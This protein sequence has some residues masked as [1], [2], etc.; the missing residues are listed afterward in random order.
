[1]RAVFAAITLIA[2]A[3][4]GGGP[5][6]YPP[7]A[8]ARFHADCPADNPVCVCT[9]EKFTEAM[10]YEEYEAALARM[11]ERGLMD[12]R[13]TRASAAC[14]ERHRSSSGQ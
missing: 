4:C 3:G 10:P 11:E 5:H 2:L 7:E 8:Q 1:M 13:M 6:P 14:R 9:W 12:P